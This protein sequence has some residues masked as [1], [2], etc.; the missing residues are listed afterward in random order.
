MNK[1]IPCRNCANKKGPFPGY[2]YENGYTVECECH[3]K[4]FKEY[5]VERK[6]KESNIQPDYNWS[7]YRGEKSRKDLECLKKYGDDFEKYKYKTMVYLYGKN[8]CQKS[9]MVQVLGKDLIRKGY[10]VEYI[11]MNNLISIL[12]K[13]FSNDEDIQ[14]MRLYNINRLNKCDLL[15][16]DES[17]DP[18]KVLM[19]KSGYQLPYLDNFLRMRFEINK[20]SII[21]VSNV[22]PNEIGANGYE[23]SLQDFVCRN[24]KNS[25]LQFLDNYDLN[26]NADLDTKGLFK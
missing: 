7:D 24:T 19:Y 17:F 4:W 18:T 8:G 23:K 3:K 13:D 1:F 26:A 20:K 10:K 22:K 25:L 2:Y 9:S 6:C 21:F 15:I 14:E 11:T 16:I 12:E 5:D